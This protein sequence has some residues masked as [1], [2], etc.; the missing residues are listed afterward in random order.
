MVFSAGMVSAR[1][2]EPY[3]TCNQVFPDEIARAETPLLV[4][5]ACELASER[6]VPPMECDVAVAARE[7]VNPWLTVRLSM[8]PPFVPLPAELPVRATARVYACAL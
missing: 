6:G 7:S 8:A 3:N 4:G 2:I 1:C 5:C